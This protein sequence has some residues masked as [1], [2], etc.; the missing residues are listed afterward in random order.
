MI[1]TATVTTAGATMP[2]MD[3]GGMDGMG[4]MPMPDGGYHIMLMGLKQA[5]KEG[6]SF[7]VT[8]NFDKAG[9]MIRPELPLSSCRRWAIQPP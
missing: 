1:A 5:L 9:Q 4:N 3:R 8:L 2:S 6:N 7:P